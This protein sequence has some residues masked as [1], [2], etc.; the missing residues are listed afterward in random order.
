MKI[1]LFGACL[2]F[3][4][5]SILG[6]DLPLFAQNNTSTAQTTVSLS[7]LPTDQLDVPTITLDRIG[8]DGLIFVLGPITLIDNTIL[9]GETA[10]IFIQPDGTN[11]YIVLEGTTDANGE[12]IYD[13]TLTLAQQNLTIVQ[14]D[15]SI[16]DLI[17][18]YN[19][20]TDAYGLA[21]YNNQSE[22]SNRVD[23]DAILDTPELTLERIGDTD[24]LLFELGPIELEDGTVVVGQP[25]QLHINPG[26][27]TEYIVLEGIT[28]QNGELTFDSFQTPASQGLTIVSGDP[29]LLDSINAYND[30]P[31]AYGIGNAF[32]ENIQSNNVSYTAPQLDEPL[33]TL[34]RI[35][36]TDGLLFTL[37]PIELDDG[38]VVTNQPAR[39]HINPGGT[40]EYIVLEGITDDN[41]VLTFDSS[42]P[43][44]DQGLT[45]VSGDSSL[46]DDIN[47]FNDITDAFGVGTAF[48]QEAESN[49]VSYDGIQLAEPTI[50]LERI[51]TTDGLL[52]TLGPIEL[53]DGTL[54]SNDRA[55]IFIRPEGRS[56]YIILEGITNDDGILTY[57]SSLTLEEQGLTIVGGDPNILTLI[58]ASNDIIDTYGLGFFEDQEAESNNDNYIAPEVDIPRTGGTNITFTI[59]SLSA[60]VLALASLT[61][62]TNKRKSKSLSKVKTK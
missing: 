28:D 24:G 43:L 31:D 19:D 27:T 26:G 58:N 39:L 51:G 59:I 17:S 37:G 38:T 42:L 32:D 9:S 36:N 13:S 54:I 45:I 55:Q 49:R 15:P 12:L 22:E 52:F 53:R 48:Q 60:L 46:L 20:V 1:T 57:N 41:G 40:T 33:L 5:I 34:N 44:G 56:D 14:G 2:C 11:D 25:A 18:A 62:F 10:Q 29:S 3:L 4:I 47:A 50:V 23:Y 7:V 30:I 6:T 21:F 8:D 35:G 16:L 61:Y